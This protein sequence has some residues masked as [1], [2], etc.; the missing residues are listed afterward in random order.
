MLFS[1]YTINNRVNRIK[2]FFRFN[3]FHAFEMDFPA[4]VPPV[5][6]ARPALNRIVLNNNR[7]WGQGPESQTRSCGPENR[8]CGNFHRRCHMQG[9]GIIAY[10]GKAHRYYRAG[11][12]YGKLSCKVHDMIVSQR[13]A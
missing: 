8:D 12:R 10:K 3:S 2:Y 4:F 9:R 5:P 13:L 6:S 7:S 11:F 1:V